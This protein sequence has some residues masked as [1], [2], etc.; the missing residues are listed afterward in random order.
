MGTFIA[1]DLRNAAKLGRDRANLDP[2]VAIDDAVLLA[3]IER[4]AGQTRGDIFD[5]TKEGP[6]QFGRVGDHETLP[7]L[8]L[9]LPARLDAPDRARRGAARTPAPA[10]PPAHGI[11]LP[12]HDP[13]V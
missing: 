8:N 9:R 11:S 6:Y 5:A 7:K 4:R 1:S 13:A 2:H 10:P 3:A 12:R